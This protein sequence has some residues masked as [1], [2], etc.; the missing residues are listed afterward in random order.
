[1]GGKR[2]SHLPQPSVRR[3][4]LLQ[5]VVGGLTLK[6]SKKKSRHVSAYSRGFVFS[7]VLHEIRQLVM[8]SDDEDEQH[9]NDNDKDWIYD[10]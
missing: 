2:T 5:G 1:M 7:K 8:G 10:E 9:D 4:N 3:L 6:H